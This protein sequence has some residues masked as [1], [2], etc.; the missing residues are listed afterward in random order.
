MQWIFDFVQV[1][2]MTCL[3]HNRRVLVLLVGSGLNL[4]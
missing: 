1:D 2:T 4:F 3:L